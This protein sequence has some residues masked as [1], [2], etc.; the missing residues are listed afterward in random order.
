M[1]Y[2]AAVSCGAVAGQVHR[3]CRLKVE[4]DLDQ[5]R[6][7]SRDDTT[8]ARYHDDVLPGWQRRMGWRQE[9]MLGADLRKQDR[10]REALELLVP[11]ASH[12]EPTKPSFFCIAA[13]CEIAEIAVARQDESLLRKVLHRLSVWGQRRIHV[14]K[15]VWAEGSFHELSAVLCLLRG[16]EVTA[17]SHLDERSIKSAS[18]LERLAKLDQILMYGDL[19]DPQSWESYIQERDEITWERLHLMAS[20]SPA[21]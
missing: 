1:V 10:H 16:N 4:S 15:E 17:K 9:L 5:V 11:I 8:I 19:N 18:C 7:E 20:V 13:L 21:S 12:E 6:I 14:G 2:L 3:G